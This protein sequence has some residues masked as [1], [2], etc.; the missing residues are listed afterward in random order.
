[1]TKLSIIVP[2]FNCE[3]TV[4]QAVESIFRQE[5]Q[6]PFDVTMVDDGSTDHT[7]VVLDKIKA[8]YP[9]IKLVRHPS[10]RGGGA[11]RQHRRLPTATGRSY[12]ALTV[13]TCS[14]PTS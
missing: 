1:M 7:Y 13:T 8:Q 5:S 12:S 4:E 11:A 2:C 14:G 9:N 10:N 6:L 3:N